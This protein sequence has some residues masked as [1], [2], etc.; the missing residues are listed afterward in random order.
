MDL[1][2]HG[3]GEGLNVTQARPEEVES[4]VEE[5]DEVVEG[6]SRKAPKRRS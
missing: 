3:L 4:N 2:D 5:R 6:A 1:P